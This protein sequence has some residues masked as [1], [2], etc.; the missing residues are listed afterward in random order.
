MK[1]KYYGKCGGCPWFNVPYKEQLKLK[2]EKIKEY[3][4]FDKIKLFYGKRYHY[5]NRMDFVFSKYGL[6]LREKKKW[7]KIVGIKKCLIANEKINLLMNEINEFFNGE[8]YFNLKNQKGTYKYAVIRISKYN[9]S[10]SFVLNE[11]SENLKNALSKIKRFSRV[12]SAENV[13]ATFVKKKSD[14]S[15]SDKYNVI[16]GSDLMCE[17][18]LG[19]K[20][21]YN[22]Q[23]FF[24]TNCNLIEKLHEYC[25]RIIKRYKTSEMNFIDLYGGVGT[26]GVINSNLFKKVKIVESDRTC[27][28]SA[29]RNIKLNKVKNVDVI[30]CDAKDVVKKEFKGPLFMIVDP[31]RAGM[32]PKVAK[33]INKIFQPEVLIYVSCNAKRFGEELHY[34]DNYKIKSVA[35][36]DLFPNTPHVE[37]ITE[38]VLV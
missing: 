13:I 3:L 26:F 20:F 37:T 1:C 31:P 19:K 27:V 29:K 12:T 36:F 5:R 32:H 14:V 2:K 25:H 11:N 21:V 18:I 23:G 10:I 28:N 16:K 15:F 6:G 33:A 8:D 24:Q 17:T 38:M 35:M 22:V 9:S 34:F 4:G 30:C 7:Y